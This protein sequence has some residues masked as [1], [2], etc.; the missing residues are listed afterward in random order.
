MGELRL[1]LVG[2][3]RLAERGYA[4]ALARAAGVRLAA[5][6]DP[7]RTRCEAVGPGVPA[8]PSAGELL[9]ARAADVLVLAT[10]AASH[11]PDS[12]LAAAAGVPTLVE[13]PPA[14][15]LQ[16]TT[17]L[18]ALDPPPWLALGLRTALGE[19]FRGSP[20]VPSLA[21]Q[22]EAFARAARGEPERDLAKA[23]DGV[24][25]MRTLECVTS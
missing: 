1:G 20:L 23:V 14:P 10:P 11:L 13:K 22:L 8:F 24:R 25:V 5:V 2:C 16:E 12:R 17:E 18:A 3:G 19:R 9:D 15:T 7:V 21:L 4:P 6:A